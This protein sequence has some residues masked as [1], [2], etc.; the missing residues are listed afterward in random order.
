MGMAPRP[1]DL[2][3]FFHWTCGAAMLWA[4]H[5]STVAKSGAA[6]RRLSGGA[7][8]D[9][10][11]RAGVRR[12]GVGHGRR[13]RLVRALRAATVPGGGARRAGGH[14]AGR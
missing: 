13:R 8:A 3:R 7:G 5:G 4:G 14:G 1:E 11:V 6:G 12:R 2:R 10:A 9:A